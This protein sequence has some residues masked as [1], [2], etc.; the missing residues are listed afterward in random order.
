MLEIA[1]S[2]VGMFY[3]NELLRRQLALHTQ[4]STTKLSMP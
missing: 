1:T 4:S 2:Q 3:E